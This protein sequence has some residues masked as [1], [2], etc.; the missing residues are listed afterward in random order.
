MKIPGRV[1]LIQDLEVDDVSKAAGV[2][3]EACSEIDYEAMHMF[4][5]LIDWFAMLLWVNRCIDKVIKG[6]YD[7][8]PKNVS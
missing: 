5:E 3:D 1:E 6:I 2:D 8:S 7:V 4:S